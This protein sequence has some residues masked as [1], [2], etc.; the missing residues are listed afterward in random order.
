MNRY[1][2]CR[3][4]P[5]ADIKVNPHILAMAILSIRVSE[6]LLLKTAST[7]TSGIPIIRF[8]TINGP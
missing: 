7:K 3:K 2:P 1:K 8:Q 6:W 5:L 4:N